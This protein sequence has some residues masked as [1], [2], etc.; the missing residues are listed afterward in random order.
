MTAFNVTLL[1]VANIASVALCL[2]APRNERV[3]SVFCFVACALASLI[4][5]LLVS[6]LR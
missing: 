2:S 5:M 3:V 6:H 1:L 4:A